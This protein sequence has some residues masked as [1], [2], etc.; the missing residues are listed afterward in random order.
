MK[1]PAIFFSLPPTQ[2]E[3]KKLYG[4]IWRSRFGP[5]D[6]VNVASPELIS[7]VIRQEGRYP[8]RSE[9]PHW[10]EYR[11]MRGQA[12]GLHV[13]KGLQWYRIRSVLNPKLLKLE[14]VSAYAPVIHQVVGDLLQHIERLRLRSQDHTTLCVVLIVQCVLSVPAG[15]S[16]IL[17]EMRLGCLQEEIPKDTLKF[18]AAANDML[19]LSETVLFLP[20]WTRNVLPFWKRFVQAWDN[21]VDVGIHGRFDHNMDAQVLAGKQVEGMY[22]TYLLSCDKLTLGEVY[23]SITE[24]LLGGVDTTSNTLSWALYHLARDAASQDRLYREIMSVCPGRLQPRSKDL[25]RMPYLKAVIKETLR[26]YPVVPGNGRLTVDNEV[27]V[28][29]YWFPKKTQFHLCHYAASHDEGEFVDAECF[30]P[31]RWLR[32][33]PESYQHHPYS[34]I[35]FGV[36]V[37]ACVGKRVAELEMYFALSRVN[38]RKDGAP[39]T[40]PKTRTLLIPSKPINLRFLPRA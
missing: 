21:L 11:D 4:P 17:F 10:K 30:R 40:E 2:V 3:H 32:G 7:Q 9:L 36:G 27:V 24:L 29:N 15:I 28:D 6:V 16:S 34:S 25:S 5:F 19:T 22:L 31:E 35:P 39:T 33:D 37:R 20:L 12:Y 18:I 26:M 14:E 1:N 13:D 23:I 8:V 38:K